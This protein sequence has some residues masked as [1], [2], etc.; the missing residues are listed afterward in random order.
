MKDKWLDIPKISC[1]LFFISEISNIMFKGG[2][3]WHMVTL[4]ACKNM[5]THRG[6]TLE[7]RGKRNSRQR[8]GGVE[9]RSFCY[10]SRQDR[11]GNR[12]HTF[13]LA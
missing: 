3:F 9:D 13:S 6:L 12:N 8:G 11:S 2:A 7:I 10:V 5:V 4:G 1:L